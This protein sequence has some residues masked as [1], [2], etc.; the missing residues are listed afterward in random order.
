MSEPAPP[1]RSSLPIPPIRISLPAPPLI[2][3]LPSLRRLVP[4]RISSPSLPEHT[5]SLSCAV[6]PR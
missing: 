1:S 2:I 5:L 4:I 3:S 6:C